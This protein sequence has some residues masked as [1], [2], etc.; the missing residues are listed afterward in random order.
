MQDKYIP[1]NPP[2]EGWMSENELQWL[3]E[4]GKEHAF[5]AEIGCWF[6]RVHP[7]ATKWK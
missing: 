7:R 2:I 1:P 5:I 6:G 3:Y 4:R